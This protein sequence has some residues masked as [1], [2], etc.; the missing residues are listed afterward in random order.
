MLVRE[1]MGGKETDANLFV[2]TE[3]LKPILQDL[4]T[5]GLRL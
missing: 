4:R 1:I 2:S 5:R 3:L